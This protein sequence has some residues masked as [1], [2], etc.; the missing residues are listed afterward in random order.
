[1]EEKKKS[2]KKKTFSKLPVKKRV[3]PV[4]LQAEPVI[5]E[6]EKKKNPVKND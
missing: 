5:R 1:M 3:N 2:V 4:K 6:T